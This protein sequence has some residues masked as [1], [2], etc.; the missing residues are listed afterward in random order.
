LDYSKHHNTYL[1]ENKFDVITGYPSNIHPQKLKYFFSSNSSKHHN[2]YLLENKFDVI[3]SYPSN[4][5]P[6]KLKYFFSSNSTRD[7][8]RI[9]RKCLIRQI[10]EPTLSH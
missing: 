7:Q 3:T 4:I 1:L 5:H 8:T 2:T 10:F 6:Q 9:T